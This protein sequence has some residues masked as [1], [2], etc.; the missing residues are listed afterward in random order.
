M[1]PK[2]HFELSKFWLIGHLEEPK[3]PLTKNNLKKLYEH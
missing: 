1:I 2:E 3:Q